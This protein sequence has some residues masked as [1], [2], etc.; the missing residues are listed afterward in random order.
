VLVYLDAMDKSEVGQGE[1]SAMGL[2]RHQ[3]P[4]KEVTCFYISYDAVVHDG[5]CA[6][7]RLLP[8]IV[9][10]EGGV[11]ALAMRHAAEAAP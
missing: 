2:R 8:N 11:D 4:R 1:W 7:I 9:S 10:C 6:V 3:V 5:Y